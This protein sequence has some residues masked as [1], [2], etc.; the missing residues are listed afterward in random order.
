MA[1]VVVLLGFN[2]YYWTMLPGVG[3]ADTAAL[4]YRVWRFQLKSD[5]GLALAHP[6]YILLARGMAFLPVGNF[7]SRVT[8]F[9]VVCGAV[10]LGFA[11]DLLRRLSG[12]V[13][14]ATVGTL[15]LAVSHTFWRD[16]VIAEK[17]SLYALGLLVELWL[18][19]RFVR[20]RH[21]KWFLLALLVNGLNFS[22]HDLALLHAPA[23]LGLI[24]W[25]LRSR[26]I[27][28]RHVALGALLFLIGS[29]PMTLL[30]VSQM[31]EGQSPWAVVKEALMGKLLES[32]VL[33]TRFPLVQQVTRSL[34]Y[35]LLNFPTP[36]ALLMP[37]GVYCSWKDPRLR[38]FVLFA[39]A[40][41]VMDYLFSF[42]YMFPGGVFVFFISDFVIFALFIGLAVPTVMKPSAFKAVLFCLLALTPVVFYEIAPEVARKSGFS[43]G[44]QREI[45]LRDS[46]TF[47]LRPRKNNDYS[48]ELYARAALKQAAP[49]GLIIADTTVK[50]P[51]VFVRD[52]EGV[53]PGVAINVGIDVTGLPP[54]VELTPEAIEPFVRRGKAYVVTDRPEY[55]F[56]W[57]RDNYELEPAGDPPGIV[58]R[59]KAK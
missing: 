46:L 20:S 30:M 51:L 44:T 24:V 49:D 21:P 25:A 56:D 32:S 4:Q 7:A 27:A 57:I 59:M 28:I 8:L 47:F 16:A 9:T 12:S 1:L 45:P 17:Y 34:E 35:F 15:T 14:A 2:L 29:L 52:A 18:V 55:L 3:W 53:E 40:I 11:F 23:Y 37:W 43:I 10:S 50:N 26:A 54:E 42:R 41:F 19:E 38:W 36:L 33:A 22:C 31:V 5:L 58:Y 6:L 13:L 48:A 39:G